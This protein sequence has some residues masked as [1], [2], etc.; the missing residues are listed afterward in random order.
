[1]QRLVEATGHSPSLPDYA[2]GFIQ[3]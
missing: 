1:M 3:V 2:T